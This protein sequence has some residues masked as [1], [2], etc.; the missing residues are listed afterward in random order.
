MSMGTLVGFLGTWGLI[1]GSIVISTSSWG[2]FLNLPSFLMVVGGTVFCLF[3]GYETKSAIDTLRSI[4]S[5]FFTHKQSQAN[6]KEEVGRVIRWGYIV[7]KNG[8]QGL[9]GDSEG[10]AQKDMFLGFGIDLVVTGYTGDEIRDILTATV[11]TI[12]ERAKVRVDILRDMGGNA[13]AYGMIGTLIGLIIMLGNMGGDASAIG[14]G[15]AVA[16]ITTLYGI[17]FARIILIPTAAKLKQREEATRFKNYLLTEGLVL[18]AERK[19][20][21]YIQDKMNSYLDPKD[22]YSIDRDMTDRP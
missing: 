17:W 4:S 3:I 9:E 15:M 2:V 8:L 22:H 10:V 7:Q 19:S 14:P 1:I 21:R 12:F 13:P 6:L 20:P 11:E 16:L 5:I 18:L